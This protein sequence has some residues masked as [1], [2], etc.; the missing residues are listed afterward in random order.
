MN[1]FF[2]FIL[3]FLLFIII[4][5]LFNNYTSKNNKQLNLVDNKNYI[6]YDIHDSDYKKIIFKDNNYTILPFKSNQKWI[7][8][9]KLNSDFTSMVNFNVKGKPNPPPIDI[10]LRLVN[11][12]DNNDKNLAAVF[13]DPT[14]KISPP[15]IPLNIWYNV[16]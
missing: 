5:N 15:N 3:V 16:N 7:V 6:F 9:G 12:L 14:G 8:N 13:F 11:I 1:K 2:Y 4:Y 10:Q